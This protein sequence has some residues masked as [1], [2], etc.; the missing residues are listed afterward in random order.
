MENF[1]W[2]KEK[3]DLNIKK[4]NVSFEESLTVFD[5]PLGIYKPDDEHSIS[6]E[7]GYLIG[8]SYKNRLLVVSFTERNNKIRIITARLATKNERKYYENQS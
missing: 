6:E 7:R 3:A 2:H 5:D 1:E 4:H 8:N